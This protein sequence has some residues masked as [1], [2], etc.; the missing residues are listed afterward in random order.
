MS[1]EQHELPTATTHLVQDLLDLMSLEQVRVTD[2]HNTLEVFQE[3]YE[4]LTAPTH[5]RCS[6]NSHELLTAPTHYRCP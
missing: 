5:Y 3:Q 6:K 1:L 4:L 2:R